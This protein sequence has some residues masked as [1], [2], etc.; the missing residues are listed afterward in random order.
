[1]HFRLLMCPLFKGFS[2]VETE[3]LLSKTRYQ[4]LNF[5]DKEV[6]QYAGESID[7]LWIVLEGKVKGEMIDEALKIVK[8]E[9]IPAPLPLA[10]AFMFCSKN[11]FPVTVTSNGKSKLIRI[12]KSSVLEMMNKN[13]KF[14]QNFLTLVSNKAKFLS[15]RIY[16]LSFNTIKQKIAHYIMDEAIGGSSF[17]MNIS[18]Q[19]LADFF[20][21]ARPSLSRTIS[22]MEAEGI[23]EYDKKTFTILDREKLVKLL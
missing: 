19:E 6:I 7:Y 14:L 18:Q 2:P 16:F 22:E 8:I 23:I 21:V 12:E 17:K 9:D 20:G 15:D 5:L 1:M 11:K 10:I 4:Y 13:Q 3:E